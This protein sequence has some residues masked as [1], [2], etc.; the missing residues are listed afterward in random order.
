MTC[1]QNATVCIESGHIF[2][3]AIHCTIRHNVRHNEL[4]F[5]CFIYENVDIMFIEIYLIK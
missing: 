3:I 4:F 5:P 1:T 2:A